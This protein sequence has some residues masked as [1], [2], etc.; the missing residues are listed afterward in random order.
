M[1]TIEFD[2][3]GAA[4]AASRYSGD[5]NPVLGEGEREVTEAEFALY[6]DC[7]LQDGVVIAFTRPT[8]VPAEVSL[9]QFKAVLFATPSTATPGKT[10]L[11]DVGAWVASRGGLAALAW[12]AA[13]V[14][15]RRSQTV[16]EGQAQ[17]GLT[18]AQMDAMF[19]QAAA[20]RV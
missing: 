1:L 20:V 7:R 8:P 12:S 5:A 9:F 15:E 16:L 17:L 19:V 11:D 2:A 18:D 13:S 10:M 3:T 4:V 14:V 6:P